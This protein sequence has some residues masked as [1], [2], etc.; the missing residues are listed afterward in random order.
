MGD[1]EAAG[2]VAV[3][4]SG[5]A[6]SSVLIAELLERH[7]AV[8]PIFVRGGLHWEDAELEHLRRFLAAI[9]C[10]PLRPLCLLDQPVCDVYGEH[11]STTGRGVPG[12]D[13]NDGA[14]FLPGRNLFLLT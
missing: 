1:A 6:D 3:L 8:L 5:G 14:V 13:T 4:A 10:P 12:A 7:P 9:A 11:W 2:P